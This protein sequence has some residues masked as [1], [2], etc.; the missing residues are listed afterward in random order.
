MTGDP[1]YVHEKTSF[2]SKR[3]HYDRSS[4]VPGFLRFV[5]AFSSVFHHCLAHNFC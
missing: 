3:A 1:E 5:G 2:F 4:D